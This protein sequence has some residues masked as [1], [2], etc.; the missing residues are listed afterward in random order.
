MV[1]QTEHNI[2]SQMVERSTH[3]ICYQQLTWASEDSNRS[4]LQNVMFCS[5]YLILDKVQI[6][7][8]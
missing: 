4:T 1:F 5:E 8:Q 3:L 7:H 2:D 6:T